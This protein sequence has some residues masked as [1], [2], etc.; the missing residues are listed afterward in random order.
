MARRV[1]I[2]E[3]DPD[4]IQLLYYVVARAGCEPVLASGG[5]QGLRLAQKGGVDLVLLDLMMDDMDGWSTLEA[6]KAD[7]ALRPV[8]VIIVTVKQEVEDYDQIE[9][10]AGMFEDWVAKPFRVDELMD[11]I[12]EILGS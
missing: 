5:R 1:L 11:R 9:A 12:T 7:E 8:P 10:H 6:L 4:I 2:I 3:D